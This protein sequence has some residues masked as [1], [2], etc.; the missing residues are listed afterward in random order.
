[1]NRNDELGTEP[2]ELSS[3]KVNELPDKISEQLKNHESKWKNLLS[4]VDIKRIQQE[5][6]EKYLNSLDQK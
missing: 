5:V 4:E 3:S 6:H 1:L 2:T